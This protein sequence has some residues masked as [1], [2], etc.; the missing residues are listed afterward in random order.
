MGA[1]TVFIIG[2][3]IFTFFFTAYT[4]WNWVNPESFMGVLGFLILWSILETVA[5]TV[6]GAI[7]MSG[8]ASIDDSNNRR[9][10]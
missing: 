1:A 4:A 10:Y 2:L 6:I 3:Q 7:A 5:H 8:I 9:N